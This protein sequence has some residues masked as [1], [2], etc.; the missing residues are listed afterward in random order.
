MQPISPFPLKSFN[1]FGL[2]AQAKMGF[3]LNNEAE[4]DSQKV[5]L[6]SLI[7]SDIVENFVKSKLSYK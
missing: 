1:T 3:V 4:L 6:Y 2:D 5:E 7:G